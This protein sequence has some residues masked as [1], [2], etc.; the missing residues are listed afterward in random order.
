[1][2]QSTADIKDYR[3]SAIPVSIFSRSFPS[4]KFYSYF[5]WLVFKAGFMAKRGGYDNTSW[6]QNSLDLLQTLENVGVC[7]DIT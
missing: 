5:I 7:F 4:L 2:T 6:R 1:M 3:T